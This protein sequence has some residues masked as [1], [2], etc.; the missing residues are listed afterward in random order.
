VKNEMQQQNISSYGMNKI[1]TDIAFSIWG[2]DIEDLE[3]R[4]KKIKAL[5]L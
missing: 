2:L 4:I 5:N 3:K 1:N